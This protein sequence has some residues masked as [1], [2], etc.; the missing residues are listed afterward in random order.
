[1]SRSAKTS[2]LTSRTELET[3]AVHLLLE[4][5]SLNSV[6]LSIMDISFTLPAET[7]TSES[8]KKPSSFFTLSFSISLA[9]KAT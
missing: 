3:T 7:S 9:S 8:T 1:L 2:A 5:I 4:T 6:P